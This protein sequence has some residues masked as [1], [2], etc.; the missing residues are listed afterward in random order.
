VRGA[1]PEPSAWTQRRVSRTTTSI[2]CKLSVMQYLDRLTDTTSATLKDWLLPRLHEAAMV[3]LRTGFFTVGAAELIEPPLA[4]MLEDRG[5]L[6]VVV[7]GQPEQTDPAALRVFAGLVA[8]FPG[9][10]K[11]YLATPRA[12]SACKDVLRPCP[13]W[14]IH[15]ICGLRQPHTS[16][17]GDKRRSCGCPGRPRR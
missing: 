11:V 3:G 10:A 7:G 9:Q 8:R 14:P 4:R 12:P 15:R 2:T 13:G 17:S 5:Q 16:W 6:Y 1:N